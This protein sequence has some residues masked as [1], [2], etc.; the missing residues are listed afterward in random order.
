VRRAIEAVVDDAIAK[1]DV[2]GANLGLDIQ[3]V[4]SGGA[5]DANTSSWAG[6]ATLDGLGTGG[7]LAHNPG[8]YIEL[9]YLP[10]RIALVMGLVKRLGH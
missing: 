6:A 10:R 2:A 8:E 7:G 4:S 1:S 3:D 5:S 9:D